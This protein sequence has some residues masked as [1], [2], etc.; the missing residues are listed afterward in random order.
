[1]DTGEPPSDCG[2]RLSHSGN[3]SASMIGESPILIS[4]WPT[5]PAG[6]SMRITSTAPNACL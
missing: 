4:A 2:L 3:S 6:P 5:L 1:M